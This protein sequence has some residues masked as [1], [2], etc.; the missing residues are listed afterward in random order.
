L[1]WVLSWFGLFIQRDFFYCPP[2]IVGE[3][4]VWVFVGL[5]VLF[6]HFVNSLI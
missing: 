4:G 5:L 2:D 6:N 1:V 3:G